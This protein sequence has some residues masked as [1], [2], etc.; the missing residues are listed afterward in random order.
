[1]QFHTGAPWSRPGGYRGL[2]V[3]ALVALTTLS[4]LVRVESADPVREARVKRGK[5]ED[6]AD[7]VEHGRH[8]QARAKLAK[9]DGGAILNQWHTRTEWTPTQGQKVAV[10]RVHLYSGETCGATC[11]G[12]ADQCPLTPPA[13]WECRDD[14][15][16]F[17][18]A[19]EGSLFSEVGPQLT[20]SVGSPLSRTWTDLFWL[21]YNGAKNTWYTTMEGQNQ[22]F[23]LGTGGN[24]ADLLRPY[25]KDNEPGIVGPNGLMYVAA[26]TYPEACIVNKEPQGPYTEPY[27]ALMQ[28]NA[29]IS[30]GAG[31]P[32]NA[33]YSAIVPIGDCYYGRWFNKDGI[34]LSLDD[35]CTE[36]GNPADYD[37]CYNYENPTSSIYSWSARNNFL[38]CRPQFWEP[39][40][41]GSN[42]LSAGTVAGIVIAVL[43]VVGAVGVMVWAWFKKWWCWK[44]RVDTADGL[45]EVPYHV[46]D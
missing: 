33:F 17:Y 34:W 32:S 11:N 24:Y 39:T 3:A 13:D 21:S 27:V 25:N 4:G 9:E 44:P 1:M 5:Y 6:H 30:E 46:Q 31:C 22:K 18:V 40:S 41:S 16:E 37:T 19:T 20:W 36:F 15:V 26:N 38:H 14:G 23:E 7:H 45:L 42:G 10:S 43:L 12:D 2:V 29:T 35:G 28:Y 8:E